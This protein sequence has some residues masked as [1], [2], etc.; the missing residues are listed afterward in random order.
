MPI[1]PKPSTVKDGPYQIS[2]C[3]IQTTHEMKEA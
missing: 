1:E 3:R 2:D